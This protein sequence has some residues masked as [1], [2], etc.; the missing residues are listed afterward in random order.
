MLWYYNTFFF[1]FPPKNN[2]NFFLSSQDHLYSVTQE[3]F[4]LGDNI[5]I[6]FYVTILDENLSIFSQSLQLTSFVCGRAV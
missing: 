2:E 5:L 3:I 4:H 1:F 6:A